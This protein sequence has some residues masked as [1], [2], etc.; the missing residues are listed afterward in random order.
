[1]A[2]PGVS[3]GKTIEFRIVS[4]LERAKDAIP[5]P[6]ALQKKICILDGAPH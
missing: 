6:S 5:I 4:P 3:L 1:M 2:A